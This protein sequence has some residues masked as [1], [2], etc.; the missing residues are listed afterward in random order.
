MAPI[1]PTDRTRKIYLDKLYTTLGK[2]SSYG[3]VQALYNEVMTENKYDINK[4]EIAE[5]LQSVDAYTLHGRVQKIFR[6]QRVIVGGMQELYQSDL[7]D[8]QRLSRYNNGFRYII[9]VI[10]CFSKKAWAE[11]LK[12]KG[13][14]SVVQALS[15]IFKVTPTPV[16]FQTDHGIEYTSHITENYLKR[17]NIVHIMSHGNQKSQFAERLIRSLKAMLWRYFDHSKTYKYIDVLGKL[18]ATYNTRFHTTIKMSPN[19][20]NERN[21][22]QV[23]NTVY[24]DLER[25]EIRHLKPKFRVGDFVRI[26]KWKHSFEKSYEE[27]YTK[28]IFRI[29]QVLDGYVMQYRLTDLQNEDILGKFY[30]FEL[31]ATRRA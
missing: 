3:G 17:N 10:D 12:S 22:K 4:R 16:R 25:D 29:A 15:K 20:V 23:F 13:G 11:P 6:T 27:T 28:E 9:V 5:Y 14:D 1:L 30:E 19:E 18:L 31:K 2:S 26:S 21:A 7:M 24:G 8:M